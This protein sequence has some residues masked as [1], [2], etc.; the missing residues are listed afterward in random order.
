M[1][2]KGFFNKIKTFL[3][4]VKQET[5]KVSWPTKKEAIK[6]TLIVSGTSIVVAA[7]LGGLDYILRI[8]IF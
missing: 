5:R 4:E 2:K 8:I 1:E 3:S 7:F 6:Y